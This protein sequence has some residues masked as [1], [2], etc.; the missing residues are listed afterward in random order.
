MRFLFISLCFLTQTLFAQITVQQKIVHVMRMGENLA[1]IL[2]Q[3]GVSQEDFCKWNDCN[4][5]Y[6]MGDILQLGFRTVERRL[7][8]Y[9]KPTYTPDIPIQGNE[10]LS[11]IWESGFIAVYD[12]LGTLKM[13]NG[14][15]YN[16]NAYIVA[17]PSLPFGTRILIT[18]T[19][20]AK[21]VY[22][23]VKDRGPLEEGAIIE[24]SEAVA[25]ALAFEEETYPM[26]EIRLIQA[27][28]E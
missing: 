24:V 21:Q 2:L 1:T 13:A 26:I 27:H 25:E 8:P 18:N 3:K 15:K 14:E 4:Q 20:N 16:P 7:P 19:A 12:D 28:E 23:V 11:A 22:A 6:Q 17:H 10:K 5:T 9:E